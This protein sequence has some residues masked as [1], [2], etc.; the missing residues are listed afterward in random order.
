MGKTRLFVLAACSAAVVGLGAGSAF[1][2]E[3]KGPPGTPCDADPATALPACVA[4]TNF[5]GARSHSNSI[6]SYSGLND[7]KNGPTLEI[8]QTP[9]NQGPP[10][11]PGHGTCAGGTNP[12]NPPTP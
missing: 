1:A 10:G 7:M 6:C 8:T 4:N 5:T 12:N 3:V 2:G 11:A 9:A